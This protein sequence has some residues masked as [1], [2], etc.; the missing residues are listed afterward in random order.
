MRKSKTKTKSKKLPWV[1]MQITRVHLN[2]EQAVLSCCEQPT[3]GTQTYATG[4]PTAN[5]GSV[6]CCTS[7]GANGS[8]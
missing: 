5:C 8:S 7:S 6:S 1:D 4:Y 2:P 3:R